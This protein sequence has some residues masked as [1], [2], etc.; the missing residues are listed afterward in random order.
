[1]MIE[2]K[3]NRNLKSRRSEKSKWKMAKLLKFKSLSRGQRL[4]KCKNISPTLC[5]CVCIFT[6]KLSDENQ[7]DF[8]VDV[9]HLK[10][11][12]DG[13]AQISDQKIFFY[14]ESIFKKFAP[15]SEIYL[16]LFYRNPTY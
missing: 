10:Y 11:H 7:F 14:L 16:I 15:Q 5:A 8:E 3:K 13:P 1:M 12:S 2:E 6:T 9:N 4:E